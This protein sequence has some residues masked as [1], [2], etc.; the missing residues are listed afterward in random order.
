MGFGRSGIGHVSM[1][2]L[3]LTEGNPTLLSNNQFENGQV[4]PPCLK[5]LQEVCWEDLGKVSL[6][7]RGNHRK[8]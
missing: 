1:S 7:L 3:Y 5:N 8:R 2:G 6:V 4:I